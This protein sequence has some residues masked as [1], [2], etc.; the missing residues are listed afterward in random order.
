[1]AAIA[2]DG[3]GAGQA[4]DRTQPLAA[5]DQAVAHRRGDDAGASGGAG[6]IAASAASTSARRASRYS[7]SP[8][9]VVT[10]CPSRDRCSSP[11]PGGAGLTSP[12]SF[13]ISMRRL[14]LFEPCVAEARQVDAALVELQRRFERQVALLELLDDG[15]ELGD[16]GLEVLDGRDPRVSVSGR[17]VLGPR[18]A[19][20]RLETSPLTSPDVRYRRFALR[21]YSFRSLTSQVNSPCSSVTTTCEPFST[22]AASRMIAVRSAFQQTA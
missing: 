4:E 19:S 9:A 13:R 2:A 1:M 16:G 20:V 7:A 3:V 5:G 21:C 22:R 11:N 6:R 10:P 8:S 12:R 15:L 14:G 17:R 18:P